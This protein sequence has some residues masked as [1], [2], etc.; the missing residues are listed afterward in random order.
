MNYINF[1]VMT[2]E[3]EELQFQILIEK[4]AKNTIHI[5]PTLNLPQSLPNILAKTTPHRSSL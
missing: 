1:K 3:M 5:R 2:H 4:I